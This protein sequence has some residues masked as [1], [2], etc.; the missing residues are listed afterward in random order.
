MESC[1][2]APYA[3]LTCATTVRLPAGNTALVAAVNRSAARYVTGQ[4]NTV[5]TQVGG[6]GDL[7]R[8]LRAATLRIAECVSQ[9][10]V[11]LGISPATAAQRELCQNRCARCGGNT[12]AVSMSENNEGKHAEIP[13]LQLPGV[14]GELQ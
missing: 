4:P 2:V 3:S 11:V 12:A 7:V 1:E 13:D 6:G 10:L 5:Y 9:R 14:G 8:T